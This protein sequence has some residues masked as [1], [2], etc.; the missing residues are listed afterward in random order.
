[1]YIDT[2]AFVLRETRYKE[3][4]RIL[5]LFTEKLGK[6]T[7]S[8]HGALSKRS[9]VSAAT[10]SLTY[11]DFVLDF[12]KGV[13]SVREAS[14]LEYFSGL[15]TDIRKYSLA[16]YICE[17]VDA[18]CIEETS[19]SHILRMLLNALYAL[20]NDLY[21]DEQIKAAFEL[22]FLSCIGYQPDL[23]N[24]IVCGT[25][26]PVDPVFGI[27]N[28]CI[29][30]RKCHAA[31]M[32]YSISI[33]EN[34]L[35]AMRFIVSTGIKNYISFRIDDEDL[36]LLSRTIEAFFLTHTDRSFSTLEYWK[37]VK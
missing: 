18:L 5:T 4:D 13:Y 23:G 37:T 16:C 19:D 2:K 34:V 15:R 29:C 30:C 25:E 21:A 14:V 32:G 3:S 12:R 9:T 28:G 10:Q 6:I 17:A 7:A 24:C 31:S 11:S 1:M 22:R 36:K 33:N 20:S 8:A 27:D 35:K 26:D